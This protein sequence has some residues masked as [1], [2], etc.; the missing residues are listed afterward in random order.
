MWHEARPVLTELGFHLA[1]E[2]N[3]TSGAIQARDEDFARVEL[4]L[5][6]MLDFLHVMK[7]PYIGPR[8]HVV[9]KKLI[10]NFFRHPGTMLYKTMLSGWDSYMQQ[11]W[12]I[13]K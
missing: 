1:H 11:A 13:S 3:H 5:K 2:Y 6:Q 12:R 8:C 7:V 4:V 9:T 10:A